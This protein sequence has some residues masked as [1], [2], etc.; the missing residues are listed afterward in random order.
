MGLEGEVEGVGGEIGAGVH[1]V[2]AVPVQYLVHMINET[3]SQFS[4][5]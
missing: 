5:Q 1:D 4:N 2:V 3:P